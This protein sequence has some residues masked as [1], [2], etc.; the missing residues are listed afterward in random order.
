MNQ[1]WIFI[2]LLLGSFKTY[3]WGSLG[4]QV[5]CDISWRYSE[6][7]V[8]SML[9]SVAKRMGYQTFAESCMWADHIK[10]KALYKDLKLLHYVNVS[11]NKGDVAS[12]SCLLQKNNRN[13]KSKPQCIVTA[14]DYYQRRINNNELSQ[15]Q[16]DEAVL[17]IGHFVG[18]IHQPMHVSYKDD[19][20]GNRRYVV[21]QGKRLSIHSLWDSD[22]L[23]CGYKGGWRRLGQT[24][25]QQSLKHSVLPQLSPTVWA[26][27]SLAVTQK[28]YRYLPTKLPDSYCDQYHPVALRQLQLAGIRLSQ[29]LFSQ[30]LSPRP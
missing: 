2:L 24:L 28:I 6:T 4:H 21:F 12:S 18:D 9:L 15:R 23:Y 1:N 14:I 29:L 7:F 3:A 26:N 25:Y 22:I 17:L 8:R 11:K 5:V 13:Q 16:R 20:G 30:L 10:S 19:F 27:E